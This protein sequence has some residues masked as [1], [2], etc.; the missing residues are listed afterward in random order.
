MK[1]TKK[2]YTVEQGTPEYT[3][4]RFST[5]SKEE[6]Y[7]EF[8]DLEPQEANSNYEYKAINECNVVFEIDDNDINELIEDCDYTQEEAIEELIEDMDFEIED[9]E[10]IEYAD[11]IRAN[12]ATDELIDE[13]QFLLGQK[14]N[15]RL[16]KYFSLNDTSIRIADHRPNPSRLYN[17][18][19]SIVISNKDL[20]LNKFH[21]SYKSEYFTSEN[22]AEEIV[23]FIINEIE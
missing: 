18:D 19:V 3:D 23:E 1:F 13:V 17:I 9:S 15:R 5:F 16:H 11:F 20:T 4:S 7:S 8:A 14:F 12:N 21:S 10:Q 2:H 6:A 22:T